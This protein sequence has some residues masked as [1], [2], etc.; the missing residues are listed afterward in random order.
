M[1]VNLSEWARLQGTGPQTACR[2]SGDGGL[3]VA[4]VLVNARTVL[5]AP[6]AVLASAVPGGPAGSRG[7]HLMT[8]RLTRPAGRRRAGSSRTRPQSPW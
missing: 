7:C 2:W 1:D 5:V 6:D 3:P 8:R 4:A